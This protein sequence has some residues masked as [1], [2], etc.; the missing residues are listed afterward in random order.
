MPLVCAV[1]AVSLN[2]DPEERLGSSGVPSVDPEGEC[3]SCP[4]EPWS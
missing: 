4:E 3:G 2:M 1:G